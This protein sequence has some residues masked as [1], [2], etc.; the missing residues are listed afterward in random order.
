MRPLGYL[1]TPP[2]MEGATP[3][4]LFP[5]SSLVREARDNGWTLQAMYPVKA[6]STCSEDRRAAA[7]RIGSSVLRVTGEPATS[8]TMQKVV[9]AVIEA[10]D[11]ID[12]EA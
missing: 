2:D 5:G 12:R 4:F 7:A 11:E 10:M 1:I 3:M 6:L 9:D 8:E